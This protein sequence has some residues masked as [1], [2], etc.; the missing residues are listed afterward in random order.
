[1][2]GSFGA[3][4]PCARTAHC[5]AP[6]L[7]LLFNTTYPSLFTQ[8]AESEKRRQGEQ[9]AGDGEAD[10]SVIATCPSVR[11]AANSRANCLTDASP[12][13][14][15]AKIV[16][17]ARPR[18]SCI[19]VAE[20]NGLREPS[21]APQQT[22]KPPSIQTIGSTRRSPRKPRPASVIT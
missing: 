6:L 3:G 8:C 13:A 7:G 4:P 19:A 14:D 5:R 17:D 11:Q 18:K 16:A 22:T 10:L 12:D 2:T 9:K 1:M 21:V 20:I 15:G